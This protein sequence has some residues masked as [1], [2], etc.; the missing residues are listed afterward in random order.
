MRE[1]KQLKVIVLPRSLLLFSEFE[2]Q[3]FKKHY[4]Y[5]LGY[6]KHSQYIIVYNFI[7][8][9]VAFSK[10]LALFTIYYTKSYI[11]LL[12]CQYMFNQYYRG[13]YWH[14]F[15]Q[16]IKTILTASFG[17]CKIVQ[18][19][20]FRFRQKWFRVGQALRLRAGY[21]KKV[22]LK[23]PNDFV[24]YIK[25]HNPKKRTHAFFSFNRRLLKQV[26]MFMYTA[27]PATLYKGRGINIKEKPI[28]LRQGKKTLW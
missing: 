22:W 20:G 17:F 13:V 9:G 4:F 25:K 23:C 8:K 6:P 21:S 1:V 2:Q 11:Y 24:S 27:R 19:V 16:L 3:L 7:S 12:N 10:M 18:F 15:N 14:N 26:V 5:F 28:E